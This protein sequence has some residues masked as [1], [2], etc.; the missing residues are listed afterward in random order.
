LADHE[1]PEV[2]VGADDGS[3]VIV[4][5]ESGEERGRLLGHTRRIWT[6]KPR[7]LADGRRILLTASFDGMIKVWDTLTATPPQLR[8][9]NKTG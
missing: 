9:A 1:V 5:G 8:A 4:C 6:I 7:T 2:V 3:L